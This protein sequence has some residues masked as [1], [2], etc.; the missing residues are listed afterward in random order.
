MKKKICLALQGGGAHG[1]FSWGVMEAILKDGRFDIEG[2]SGASAGGYNAVALAAGFVKGGNEGAIETM[3]EFWRGV[4]ELSTKYG[5]LLSDPIGSLLGNYNLTTSLYSLTYPFWSLMLNTFS[6]YIW[7][8]LNINP[9]KEYL[10]NFFDYELIRKKSKIKLFLSAT[11]IKSGRIKFFENNDLSTDVLMATGC[12]PKLF[13]AVIIDGEAY[14][15]GGFI[16]NPA[17]F[18]LI[19]NCKSTDIVVVQLIKTQTFVIPKQAHKIAERYNEIMLNG[20]LMREIRAVHFLTRLI[21]EGKI[22][23]PSIRRINFHIIKNEKLFSEFRG[24]SAMN[25]NWTFLNTLRDAGRKAGES[26]IEE[27]FDRLGTKIPVD[28]SVFKDYL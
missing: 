20:C 16:A 7:N 26:W 28:D 18:P 2:I 4:H 13:Q 17:I 22:T 9:I 24:L 11:Q 19:Y 6:P 3:E 14:W 25:A 1:A 5:I 10:D 12:L 27:N 21:D 8:F 15:D 23:D